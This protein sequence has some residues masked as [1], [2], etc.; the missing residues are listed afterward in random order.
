M[1]IS[2]FVACFVE[3]RHKETRVIS[4][5]KCITKFCITINFFSRYKTEFSASVTELHFIDTTPLV[6]IYINIEFS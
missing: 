1:H 4:A 3:T 5:I 6:L 2:W